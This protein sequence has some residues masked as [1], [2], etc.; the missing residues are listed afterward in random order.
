MN[1]VAPTPTPTVYQA[2]G[3]NIVVTCK[4]RCERLKQLIKRLTSLENIE[5]LTTE[6]PNERN[7]MAA[8]QCVVN[9]NGNK[10]FKSVAQAKEFHEN[11]PYQDKQ[12]FWEAINR[13]NWPTEEQLAPNS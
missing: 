11:L 3:P 4:I 10:V 13:L 6:D 9:Q 2:H 12:D 5:V 8:L 1:S 7:D